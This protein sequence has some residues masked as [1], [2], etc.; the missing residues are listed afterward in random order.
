MSEKNHCNYTEY[1]IQEIIKLRYFNPNSIKYTMENLTVFPWESD[2]LLVTK[3]MYA[4]EFEIKISRSDFKNDFKHKK[5][6][7]LFLEGKTDVD[8]YGRKIHGGPNYF[9][10]VCPENMVEASEVPDYAGLIY[11]KEGTIPSRGIIRNSFIDII[12]T[13][14]KLRAEKFDPNQYNLVDKF[15]YNFAT[16]KNKYY[17]DLEMYKNKLE[18][19]K[20][21]DG[22]VQKYTYPDAIRHISNLEYEIGRLRKL[23]DQLIEDARDIILEN[24]KLKKEIE[25]ETNGEQ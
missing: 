3:S 8:N 14:P 15:Y 4:Y 17:Y 19:C 25:K 5:Q 12:K 16:W 10:Y 13:A 7:H 2:I 1:D 24:R 6:K 11:V 21:I 9:Y 23:N 22:K 20:T 18:E